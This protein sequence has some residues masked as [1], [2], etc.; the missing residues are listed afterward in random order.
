MF[1][2][3]KGNKFNGRSKSWEKTIR[4][5]RKG[6]EPPGGYDYL[7]GLILS[8]NAALNSTS[9]LPGHVHQIAI[10]TQRMADWLL[11]NYFG[12]VQVSK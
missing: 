3:F 7:E 12:M 9:P 6:I 1:K 4:N 8:S 5:A 10:K 2:T 11:R